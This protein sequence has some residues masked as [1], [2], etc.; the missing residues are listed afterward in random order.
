MIDRQKSMRIL[1]VSAV[2]P[3]EPVVS[4]YLSCDIAEGLTEEGHVVTVL[5][6][7]PTRPSGYKSYSDGNPD[8]KFRKIVLQSYTHPDSEVIGRM[9][10]SCS[11]G[12]H[13]A[14]FID[15]NYQNIDLIYANTWPLFAQYFLVKKAGKFKIPVV[16]HIQDVYPE[17]VAG[18]QPAMIK[19]PVLAVFRRFDKQNLRKCLKVVA[20]SP[21]MGNYL[22]K[23]RGLDKGRVYVVRNWQDDNKFSVVSAKSNRNDQ[24]FIFMYLGSINPSAGVETLIHAFAKADLKKTRLVIAGEGP[25]KSHC[26]KV[27]GQYPLMNIDFTTAPSDKVSEIQQQADVLLLPLRKGIARTATPSKLTAYMLSGKPI[28]AS[29]DI[30]SDTAGCIKEAKC[31]MVTEPGDIQS[32]ADGMSDLL[33][34]DKRV[35]EEFGNNGRTFAMAH[36]SR[37]VNLEK[38]IS[39]LTSEKNDYEKIDI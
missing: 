24:D 14:R 38:M 26:I 19:W 22:I 12:I 28:I 2:F 13:C 34:T 6:P 37:K 11:F 35:L 30:D 39:I 29:V 5:C 32:L 25:D 16:M 17:S 7:R 27:A 36:L 18:K 3:P 20:I 33:R 4:G 1:I 15:K 8:Y 31:G 9:R 21:A 23:T 10:E